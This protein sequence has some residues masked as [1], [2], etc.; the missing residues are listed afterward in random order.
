MRTHAGIAICGIV[1]GFLVAGPAALAQVGNFAGGHANTGRAGGFSSRGYTGS[2]TGVPG[3]IPTLAPHAIATPGQSVFTAPSHAFGPGFA[4]PAPAF[5]P[6]WNRGPWRDGS[7]HRDRDHDGDRHRDR[8][9]HHGYGGYGFY[10]GY[11][12][13]AS[14]WSLLPYDSGFSDFSSDDT[15]QTAPDSGNAPPAMDVPP[16]S[17]GYRPEYEGEPYPGPGVAAYPPATPAAPPPPL[18]PEPELTL[19]F[20]D[21]HTLAIHNYALT[22]SDV[23]VLDQADSG[24]QQRIPLVDLNLPATEQAAQQAGLDFSPPA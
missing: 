8:D 12:I 6:A 17:N 22:Q 10:G 21:G 19:I 5:Q 3:R 20:K 15:A 1:A 13:Y 16:P 11:P 4:P 7:P 23:I 14:G 18:S 9:R 2:I 24:R